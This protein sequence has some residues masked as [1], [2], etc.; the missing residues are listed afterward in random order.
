MTSALR[1]AAP[2]AALLLLAACGTTYAVPEAGEASVSQARAM[3]AAE[4]DPAVAH[5]GRLDPAAAVAQFRTVAAAVEPVAETFCRSQTEEIANFNCDIRLDIDPQATDRNAFFHFAEGGAPTVTFTVPLI[6]DAR[7]PDE[8]AFVMGHE[9]GHH[10]GR[11][12][13]KGQQQAV[14]GM[15][16]M[17]A[18]AAYGQAQMTAANPYRYTGNDS[19]QMHDM[20]GIGGAVGEAA[21]SQTY[22]LEADVIGTYIATAAGYDPVLGARF[23]ARPEQPVTASGARS[24]WGTHPAHETR[25]ATVIETRAAMVTAAAE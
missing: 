11:H 4:R 21:Y 3:F 16:I 19:Q 25:L 14:A 2:A 23:F 24:F 6:M 17:G 13:Q 18:L 15:L 12:I 20:M 5:A 9:M 7:N 8:L 10:I 22:E 1:T